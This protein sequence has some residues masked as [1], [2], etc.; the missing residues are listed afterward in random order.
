MG[1]DQRIDVALENL[2]LQQA[3]TSVCRGFYTVREQAAAAVPDWEDLRSRANAAKREVIENLPRYLDQLEAAIRSRGGHVYRAVDGAAACRYIGE[4]MSRRNVRT[5]VKSKSMATEEIGL[6]HFLEHA[7]VEPVETDLGEYIIQL[8]GEAPFHIIAPSIHKT[9]H[10]VAKL[11]KEKLNVDLDPDDIPGMC[12]LAR[13]TLREKFLSAG[14]GISGVNMAVAE[15]GTIVIVENEGNARLCTSV[16]PVHIAVMGIEKIIPRVPDL[17]VFLKLLARSATGQKL[18]SYTSLL[19]GPRREGEPDGPEE[20]HVIFLDNGRSKIQANPR[21]REALYCIRCGAC[22]NVC[23]VYRKIG[24]HAYPWVYSGPIGAILS[25]QIQ[26]LDAEPKLPFASSLCG[27]CR[28]VCPVKIRIPELLLELR[29]TEVET[30][31]QRHTWERLAFRIWAW[32]MQRPWAY[33]A[34]GLMARWL[35]GSMPVGPAAVWAK[36]R[37]LPVSPASSF[38]ELWRKRGGRR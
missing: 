30:A 33:E 16:P 23:P 37:E 1:L 36:T 7:G 9:R 15:T 22:L 20:F 28:E 6:N 24:G 11:F 32:T 12:A 4:V 13:R 31:P 19:T 26:G 21:T 2:H 35:G 18:S 34:G 8:A 5:V 25:P 3:L 27:A 38:R 14:V 10:D 17:A 29:Q